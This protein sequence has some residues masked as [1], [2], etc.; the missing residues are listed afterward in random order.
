M[1]E[2][3]ND[4]LVTKMQRAGKGEF[5]HHAL[6]KSGFYILSGKR[7]F[8][9]GMATIGLAVLSPLFLLVT[10]AIKLSSR[11]PIFYRQERVGKNG[12]SF[13][14]MK[15]RTMVRDADKVGPGVTAQGDPRVTKLGSWL[16]LF[17]ID[18]LPQL[19]N[20]LK[21][22]MSFVGPRPEIPH[23][24]AIYTES[25][26]R[27]LTVRPGIT[28]TAT[29]AYRREEDLIARHPNP[30]KY[31]RDVVLPHKLELNMQYIYRISFGYDLFLIFRT[32]QSIFGLRQK[33]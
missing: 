11:G 3:A 26:R 33:I 29:L 23:Y 16:R 7:L 21:G 32:I 28:D 14:I 9:V 2:F 6:I 1:H 31:Y 10:V 22:D 17:K 27:V 12:Q 18:E 15:F 24:V 19:W 25:Q 8:D 13:L 20:V 4:E 5:T 30:E